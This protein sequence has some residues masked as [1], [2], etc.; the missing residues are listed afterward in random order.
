MAPC[1]TPTWSWS[2][3]GTTGPRICR[4]N[5]LSSST[6]LFMMWDQCSP[7]IMVSCGGL[8]WCWEWLFQYAVSPTHMAD[9]MTSVVSSSTS[10]C[11]VC[12]SCSESR[13]LSSSLCRNLRNRSRKPT[14]GESQLV[15]FDSTLPQLHPLLLNSNLSLPD[16]EKGQMESRSG[17]KETNALVLNKNPCPL[18]CHQANYIYRGG[19]PK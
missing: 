16:F 12:S 6:M 4:I 10:C 9:G 13:R 17:G 3:C 2:L 18:V 5:S 8:V 7:T 1:H 19:V 14:R 15:V 11:R